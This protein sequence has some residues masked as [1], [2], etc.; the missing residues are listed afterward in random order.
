MPTLAACGQR[1]A[2]A[3]DL[4]LFQR[5][6]AGLVWGLGY[7]FLYQEYYDNFTL[8]QYRGWFGW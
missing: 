2:I 5:T 7:D 3:H 4:G 8:G 6:E 1:S